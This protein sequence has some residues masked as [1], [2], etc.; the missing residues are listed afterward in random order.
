MGRQLYL[1]SVLLLLKLLN[2][3]MLVIKQDLL[4]LAILMQL[5]SEFLQMRMRLA[6]TVQ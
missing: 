3:L 6:N 2:D 4:L 1:Q 5:R